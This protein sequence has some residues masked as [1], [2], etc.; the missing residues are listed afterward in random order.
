M[1][2]SEVYTMYG[3]QYYGK[4]QTWDSL[5][6]TCR[7]FTQKKQ[8]QNYCVQPISH[9]WIMEC[10]QKN[11]LLDMDNY[12]LPSGW[13]FTEEGYITWKVTRSKTSRKAVKAFR[14]VSVMIASLQPDFSTFWQRVCQLSG[15][16]TSVIKSLND[17]KETPK[18]FLLTDDDDCAEEM[19][20]KA[21]HCR[22]PAVS[23]VWVVQ[24]LIVGYPCDP[25]SNPKM[26]LAYDDEDY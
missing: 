18:A 7:L 12:I 1:Y 23:T 3:C 17:I 5:L 22:I 25:E 14:N 9:E 26:K 20:S 11:E 2:N 13:S 10:C 16:E 15:C 24:S 8:K 4:Y 21:E 19:K 6:M